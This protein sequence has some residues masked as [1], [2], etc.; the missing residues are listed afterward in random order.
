VVGAFREAAHIWRKGGVSVDASNSHLDY[1]QR[2][3]IAL[4]AEERLALGCYRA[5]AFTGRAML[6]MLVDSPD[7]RCGG[8]FYPDAERE[9]R[10]AR[11][12][13]G[14]SCPPRDRS[15]ASWSRRASAARS[16]AGC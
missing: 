6:F 10:W 4:R 3:L 12:A 13:G 8:G 16:P 15:A 5:A 7:P 11:P 2:N 9:R 1:Y 14:S